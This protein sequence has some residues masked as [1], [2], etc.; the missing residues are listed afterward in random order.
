[1][2]TV[3][4]T[5]TLPAG[6]WTHVAAVRSA[7]TVKLLV[8]HV[9]DAS[10]SYSSTLDDNDASLI[11]GANADGSYFD[12]TI[13]EVRV[14]TA[15]KSATLGEAD[16]TYVYNARNQL[17][18]ETCGLNVRTYSY[19]NNGN[20]T[21]IEE[22]VDTTVILTEEMT[23]DKLNRML[24]HEGPSGVEVFAYRGAEWRE[25]V[26]LRRR[27]RRRGL[28]QRRR[29]ILRDA[30]P[31]PEPFDNHRREHVLLQPGRPGEHPH[32]HGFHGHAQEQLR[33][34]P[35]RRNASA[36]DFGQCGAEVYVYGTREEPRVGVDVL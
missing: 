23:Y 24:R 16:V 14:A 2:S 1:V 8:D 25:A 7:N 12:G 26:P 3:S 5:L 27:Q 34:S 36:G 11:I 19:D 13:D 17:V 6:E 30:V 21:K 20:V 29:R 33:L 35:L 22:K 9:E 28:V 10:A 18:T 15:D 32:A 4:G 31:R